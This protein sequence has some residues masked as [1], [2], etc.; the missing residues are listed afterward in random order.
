MNG[1]L[2]PGQPFC[3]EVGVSDVFAFAGLWDSWQDPDGQVLETCTILTTTPND[4]LAD[5][6]DRMP[7]ILR[8][9]DHDR[10]LDPRMQD[11]ESAVALLKPF[12]ATRMRRYPVSTRVNL[13]T[14]EGPGCSAPVDLPATTG[15]LFG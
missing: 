15:L 9:E 3:F 12:D 7:A 6:H 11:V 14:N 5:V 2:R 1:A 4:L 13:V 8:V 10:W